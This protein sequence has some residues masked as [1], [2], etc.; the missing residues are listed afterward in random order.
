MAD[1]KTG[2]TLSCSL[3]NAL[4]NTGTWEDVKQLLQ[5]ANPSQTVRN[6]L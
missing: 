2:S 3:D 5:R 1:D 4:G 6:V